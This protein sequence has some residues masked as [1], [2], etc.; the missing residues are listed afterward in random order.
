MKPRGKT[1]LKR[2]PASRSAV[3]YFH[4]F[5]EGEK[6]E[7]DYF[8]ALASVLDGSKV[9]IKYNGPMGVPKT[10]ATKAIA[11]AKDNG[12]T[13]GRRQKKPESYEEQDKV[14]AVFDRDEFPCYHEAKQ[15]CDGAAIPYAYSD[16]CFEL[17]INLHFDAYDAPC[18]RHQAQDI[19]KTLI[20]DYDPKSAK[21][22]DFL[23]IIGELQNADKRAAKQRQSRIAEDSP[24]G[25]PSTNMYEL[26]RALLEA[27]KS[28]GSKKDG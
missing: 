17:W 26:I 16:P 9:R 10:V 3:Q 28:K 27:C 25:N 7:R 1:N 8:I 14:W 2:K 15:M 24:D 18:S 21:T 6:T 20:D 12:L 22:G 19:T 23:A 11:F 13:K 5:S 4:V